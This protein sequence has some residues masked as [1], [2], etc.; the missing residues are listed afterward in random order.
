[1]KEKPKTAEPAN[2]VEE[3]E[4]EVYPLYDFHDNVINI[5]V[6]EGGKVVFQQGKPKDGPP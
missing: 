1:M 2:L 5:N 4:E 3:E 6:Y